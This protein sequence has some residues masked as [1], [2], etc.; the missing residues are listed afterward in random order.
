MS[1]N[2]VSMN[3]EFDL[4]TMLDKLFCKILSLLHGQNHIPGMIFWY[5][6]R[7]YSETN[8]LAKYYAIKFL[9]LKIGKYTTGWEQLVMQKSSLDSIGAFCAIAKNVNLTEGNHPQDYISV[10]Q[11]LY[12]HIYGF[13]KGENRL[14]LL[15]KKNGKVIIGNDVWIGRDVTILPSVII[16][17]GAIIG[18]GAVVNKSIPPYAIAVGVPAKVIKYRFEQN[19]IELL[20]KI[21]WWDWSDNKIRERLGQFT[22]PTDFL[23]MYAKK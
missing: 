2:K 23:D 4:L 6:R 12:N 7:R 19:D 9:K 8:T 17:D 14:E 21:K 13:F 3:D 16:G 22:V 11:F 5:S 1:K 10:H 18:T 15:P 20:E